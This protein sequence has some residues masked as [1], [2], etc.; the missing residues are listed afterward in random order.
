[1][2]ISSS[3]RLNPLEIQA[4]RQSVAWEPGRVEVWQRVLDRALHVSS[5]SVDDRLVGIGFLIGNERHAT[6]CDLCVAP[7]MQSKGIGR[8]IVNSLI[9]QACNQEIPYVTLTY[10]EQS[11]WL[12]HFYASCGFA[13]VNNAMQLNRPLDRSARIEQ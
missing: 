12:A 11:P 8:S 2:Q 9:D 6:L 3:R 13:P 4:L 1:M 10:D 5:A 7:D